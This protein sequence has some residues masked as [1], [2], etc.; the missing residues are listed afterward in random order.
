[1][2]IIIEEEFYTI[3]DNI[4]SEFVNRY[5]G[6]VSDTPN[7]E[8][9]WLVRPG[10]SYLPKH[11]WDPDKGVGSNVWDNVVRHAIPGGGVYSA[12]RDNYFTDE[13]VP[14]PASRKV[15]DG[16]KTDGANTT[17]TRKPVDTKQGYDT[18]FRP[19]PAT[20]PTP[21]TTTADDAAKAEAAKRRIFLI[22]KSI[23]ES[24]LTTKVNVTGVMDDATLKAKAVIEAKQAELGV[25]V[26]GIWGGK[27]RDARAKQIAASGAFRGDS[28]SFEE[29]RKAQSAFNPTFKSTSNLD[30][31]GFKGGADNLYKPSFMAKPDASTGNYLDEYYAFKR[32]NPEDAAASGTTGGD[33]GTPSASTS[34]N[35]TSRRERQDRRKATRRT[36]SDS[37]TA[38]RR[39]RQDERA[40]NNHREEKRAVRKESRA[41]RKVIRQ[42]TRKKI[43]D[44]NNP[45]KKRRGGILYI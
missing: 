8:K 39:K 35:V 42:D 21:P 33:S 1:L 5:K 24:G 22:Q 10:Y 2:N 20:P 19:N 40:T 32:D 28:P 17:V 3:K 14:K 15:P 25:T 9:N 26:D 43:R 11:I 30:P 38:Q 45:E 4:M 41:K 34:S 23:N 31:Y 6:Q 12:I 44:I 7:D 36:N 16:Y 27:S 13:V 29:S 37:R 18:F